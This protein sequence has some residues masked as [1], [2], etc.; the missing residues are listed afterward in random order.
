MEATLTGFA[1]SGTQMV[2]GTPKRRAAYA[3][4]CPWFPVEAEMTPSSRSSALSCASRLTPP[5]T[6]KAPTGWWFSC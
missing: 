1:F 5:R 6:L 3:I 2:A 4:D